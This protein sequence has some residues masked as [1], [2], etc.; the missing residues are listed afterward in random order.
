MHEG[1][2]DRAA[3]TWHIAH[4]VWVCTPLEMVPVAPAAQR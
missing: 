4:P 3:G 1:E 2:E